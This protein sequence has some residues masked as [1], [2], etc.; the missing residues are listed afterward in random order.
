MKIIFILWWIV[1]GASLVWA[2]DLTGLK[3]ALNVPSEATDAQVQQA[4][5]V[6]MSDPEAPSELKSVLRSL[7]QRVYPIYQP[8]LEDRLNAIL[9][10]DMKRIGF[11]LA[12]KSMEIR[13][14]KTLQDAR[15]KNNA[16]RGN[17]PELLTLLN[18]I[19]YNLDDFLEQKPSTEK[20]LRVMDSF[21]QLQEEKL[22]MIPNIERPFVKMTQHLLNREYDPNPVI[23]KHFFKLIFSV[24]YFQPLSEDFIKLGTA[25]RS[26]K[27]GS[28]MLADFSAGKIEGIRLAHVAF[29][30]RDG[31]LPL[32]DYLQL[33]DAEAAKIQISVDELRE[34]RRN[35]G[36]IFYQLEGLDWDPKNLPKDLLTN[37]CYRM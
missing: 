29:G 16:M 7:Y 12:V 1:F 18:F 11:D 13:V 10:D 25:L 2:D 8:T 6:R 3:N 30:V 34:I 9:Y 27:T 21:V 23:Y 26:S 19:A 32:K 14:K 36:E 35:L 28:T 20:V 24:G 5:R 15:K 31:L 17:S 22:G 4:Y 37:A 33:L